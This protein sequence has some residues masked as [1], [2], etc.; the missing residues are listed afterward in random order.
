MANKKKKKSHRPRAKTALNLLA[1]KMQILGVFGRNPMT[2][3]FFGLVKLLQ[4]VE[5]ELFIITG[6]VFVLF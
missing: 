1:C 5:L 3:H 6:Y 2:E 4:F